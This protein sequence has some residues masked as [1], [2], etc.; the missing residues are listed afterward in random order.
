M[1]TLLFVTN[2]PYQTFNGKG[3]R[4]LKRNGTIQAPL[5]KD[6]AGYLNNTPLSETDIPTEALIVG[7]ADRYDALRSRW[8]YK[9]AYSHE[10]T[11]AVMT[12]DERSG[13]SGY[14][15]YGEDIWGVFEKHHLQ[16]KD[17]FESMRN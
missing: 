14:D 11:L 1:Q 9:E 15:W 17:V 3:D 12:D 16:F 8:P 7:L 13:I 5:N 6:Y 4:C 2:E 10:K